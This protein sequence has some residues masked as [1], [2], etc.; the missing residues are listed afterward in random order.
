MVLADIDDFTWKHGVQNANV[1]LACADLVDPLILEAGRDC[2]SQ[3]IFAVKGNHDLKTRFP[4]PIMDLHLQV[5]EHAGIRFG[6]FNGSWRYK[7][8]GHFLYDQDE[9]EA[10]LSSFPPV[11]ILVSHNSPR[12]IH[13]RD[14]DVH[15]GFDALNSYIARANPR[16][17]IHGH[18]HVNR[19]TETGATRVIGVFGFRIID[20]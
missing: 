12:G 8:Q 15:Y 14:D 1:V 2:G 6:G 10:L 7:S 13:D 17:I 20:I 5:R 16:F 3:A 9:A 11:D 18:Q 19:E 4:D